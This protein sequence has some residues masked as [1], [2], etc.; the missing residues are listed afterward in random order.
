MPDFLSAAESFPIREPSREPAFDLN[1]RTLAFAVRIVE[2][3][4]ALPKAEAA[5]LLGQQLLRAGTAPGALYREAQRSRAKPEF[6]PKIGECLK[7]LDETVYWLDL[8][9]QSGLL[10]AP[11]PALT[12][13]QDEASQLTAIFTSISKKTKPQP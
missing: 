11:T 6:G 4:S 5:Q 1:A 3:F 13:L 8:L 9:I 7:S 10:P 12:A 2:T